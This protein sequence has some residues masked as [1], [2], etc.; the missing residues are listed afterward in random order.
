M[1]GIEKTT[2]TPD[3]FFAGDFPIVTDFGKIRSGATIRA[4]APIVQGANGIEEAATA[5]VGNVIGITADVP[6]GGEVVYYLTGE[7]FT[8]AL[9]L[10][11]GVTAE[12]LKPAL[13]KVGIFL[14]EMN[15][16][17]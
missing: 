4:R 17:V 8:Q 15:K 14:K 12:N 10:P 13:R 1:Y 5:T 6:S 9:T 2:H 7:F 11:N 16:N 3:N